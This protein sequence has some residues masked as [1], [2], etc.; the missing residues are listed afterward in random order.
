MARNFFNSLIV[1]G[2]QDFILE[3]LLAVTAL[4]FNYTPGITVERMK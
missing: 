4:A 1:N 3:C 2:F